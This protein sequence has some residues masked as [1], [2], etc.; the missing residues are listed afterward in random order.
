MAKRKL[1]FL[2][3]YY[4]NTFLELLHTYGVSSPA[5]LKVEQKKEFFIAVKKEW[6]L[7][8]A[9]LVVTQVKE[10]PSVYKARNSSSKKESYVKVKISRSAV[11]IE[12]KK[13]DASNLFFEQAD[14]LVTILSKE[15]AA[16]T[17]ELKIV[18]EPNDF[19]NQ[20]A[21]Y[22]YP[23]VKMPQANAYLKLPRQDRGMGKGY[24]EEDFYRT[25]RSAFPNMEVKNDVHL[26]IPHFNRP[27]EPDIV[28]VDESINL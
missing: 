16:Q 26:A 19:F 27:Y 11:S 3:E 23:V 17:A 8:K 6:A 7:R 5:K 15:N 18:Y 22:T 12:P 10:E 14:T 4:R 20:D 1:S 25:I 21:P 28:L 13:R 9:A 2:Q 24:K